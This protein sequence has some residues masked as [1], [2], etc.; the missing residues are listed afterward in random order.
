MAKSPAA[1]GMVP[2]FSKLS[3]VRGRLLFLLG[4]IIVYRI[5]SFIPVPD[6]MWIDTTVPSSAQAFQKGSQWSAKREGC[7]RPVGVSGNEIA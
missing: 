4:A 2:D 3:E 6:P 1:A 7:P 5:G